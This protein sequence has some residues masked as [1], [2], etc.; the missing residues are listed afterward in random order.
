M[1]AHLKST[2]S[3]GKEM[4]TLAEWGEGEREEKHTLSSVASKPHD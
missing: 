4:M 3:T 2:K 1:G